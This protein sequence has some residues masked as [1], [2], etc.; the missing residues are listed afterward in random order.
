[1]DSTAMA[2]KPRPHIDPVNRGFWENCRR[3]ILSAQR[4]DDC[5]HLHFPASP[6]CPSC[7]SSRQSWVPVSGRGKLYSW[8]RFHRAYWDGFRGDLPYAVCA[9]K[10][11]EG[12]LLLSNFAGAAPD[13]PPLDAPVEV[14]FERVDEELTLPKFR[15]CG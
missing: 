12:P 15:L 7:L 5:A 1:M 14:V 6:V 9:V 10:L 11:D 2:P 3:G 4:C 13:D 8:V